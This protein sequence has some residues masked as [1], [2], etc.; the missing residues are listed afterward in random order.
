MPKTVLVVAGLADSLINFRGPLLQEMVGG[1]HR[2]VACADESDPLSGMTTDVPKVLKEYGVEFRPIRMSR[3]GVNPKQD[4][5][6]Y[7]DLKSIIREVRPDVAFS[8]TMKAVVWT[9]LASSALK[10]PHRVALING[11][12]L[13]VRP[14]EGKPSLTAKIGRRLYQ[15]ALRRNTR[16]IFQNSDDRDLHFDEGILPAGFPV[17][18]CNGSGVDLSSF[19]V[20]E[21]LLK[22]FTILCIARL[23]TD[24]GVREFVGASRILKR[25]YPEMRAVLVGPF[26]KHPF[27]IAE[28]EVNGWVS[29]G[30]IEYPGATKDVRPFIRDCSVYVLPSYREGTPRT[31][32]EAMALGRPIVTTDAPGCRQTTETGVNGFL[33]PV[34]DEQATADAIEKFILDPSLIASMGHAS[35]RIVEEKYDVKKVNDVVLQALG[36]R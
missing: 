4:L 16:V 1:G 7:N 23:L 12:G 5:Q 2:V 32:L 35:R 10:T 20:A 28:E 18:V 14:T 31:V 22:P 21:P 15:F 25:K 19:D 26:D 34:R 24:K 17:T 27:A 36:L 8:Y 3:T 13:G 30:I 9:S 33:V 11:L 6:T 29:E